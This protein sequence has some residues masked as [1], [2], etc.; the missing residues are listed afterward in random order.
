MGRKDGKL[1]DQVTGAAKHFGMG[2]EKKMKI[3][4]RKV[5]K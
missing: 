1:N 5:A 2:E 3:E 4:L